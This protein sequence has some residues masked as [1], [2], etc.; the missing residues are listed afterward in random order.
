MTEN[1][2]A[3]T[4]NAI[5]SDYAE[6]YDK[7]DA[8]QPYIDRL[9]D[10][11]PEN[12]SVLDIGCGNGNYTKYIED[13]GF[14]YE[15]IDISEE[16][17]NIAKKN[18]PHSTFKN[19]D[20]QKLD[21]EDATFDG[22]LSVYSLIHIPSAEIVETVKG[23]NRVLTSGGRM[24]LIV[25]KGEGEQM[26]DEPLQEK[27]KLFVNFFPKMQLQRYIQDAGFQVTYVD[28]R[29]NPQATPVPGSVI[30]MIAQKP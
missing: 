25:Q 28:E 2:T 1:T 8:D 14:R 3:L 4:Y 22:I 7:N 12:G 5:A 26:V 6:R 19:M 17:L 29:D 11:L 16:M 20:M 10:Q 9:L 30:Y 23:F 13:K 15:G 21:Y 27:D 24:L 18:N